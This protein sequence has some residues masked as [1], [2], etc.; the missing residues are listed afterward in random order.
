MHLGVKWVSVSLLLTQ[1]A[2]FLT[3][4]V[5][6]RLLV[7]EMFGIVAM[8]NVTIE[9]MRKVSEIGFGAAYIQRQD[10]DSRQD[11]IAAN[12]TFFIVLVV[13]ILIEL[14]LLY[15]IDASSDKRESELT[16]VYVI[17]ALFWPLSL[18]AFVLIIIFFR[19]INLFSK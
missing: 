3:T 4:V 16:A 10:Q 12:T 6:A 1:A 11:G 14:V 7:P 17:L 8:A 9:I 2:R 13:Y 15:L 18:V 5:L 19:I